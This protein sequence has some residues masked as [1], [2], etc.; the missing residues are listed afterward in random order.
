LIHHA[1]LLTGG[2]TFRG[3]ES[4]YSNLTGCEG[5]YLSREARTDR[6]YISSSDALAECEV[7]TMPDDSRQI[8]R[9]ND[10]CTISKTQLLRFFEAKFQMADRDQ[11]GQLNIAE[12]G[13]FLRFVTHPDLRAL[14]SWDKYS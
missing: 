13:N 8:T 11:D 12:L 3:I 10:E 5:Q 6:L 1:D 4:L 9:T 14:R 2:V 7:I